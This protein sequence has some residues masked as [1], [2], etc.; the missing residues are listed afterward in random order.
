MKTEYSR[1]GSMSES[2]IAKFQQFLFNA[3]KYNALSIFGSDVEQKKV[4]LVEVM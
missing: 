1:V 2:Q 4:I 3:Y